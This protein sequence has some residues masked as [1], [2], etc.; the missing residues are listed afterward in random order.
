MARTA[1]VEAGLETVDVRVGDVYDLGASS[2]A[3]E[4]TID[5]VH[6][7]QVLQ[8]L[9]DPVRALRLL[10]GLL[11][12]GGVLA[13]RDA[14]YAAMT[15]Y[16]DVPGLEDWRALYR[17]LS[18][19]TGGEPDAGRRLRSWALAAGFD[20]VGCSASAWCYATA[21]ERSWWSGLW[22]DRVVGS[23]IAEHAVASGAATRDD[24]E[25]LRQAWLTWGK[26]PDGWFAVLHGEVLCR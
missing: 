9:P 23:A 25:G 2:S 18:R 12:P 21:E 1:V 3:G 6:A 17:D 20:D 22:A 8:H 5:V 4:A 14:D 19:R 15:W 10:R 26:A 7:H 13:S 16:P 24:L 11:T